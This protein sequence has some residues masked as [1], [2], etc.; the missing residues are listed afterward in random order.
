[1]EIVIFVPDKLT[2]VS[3]KFVKIVVDLVL[4]GIEFGTRMNGFIRLF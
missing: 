1:M 4:D 3:G 2:Y